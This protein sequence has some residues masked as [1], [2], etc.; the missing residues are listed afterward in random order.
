MLDKKII[1]SFEQLYVVNAKVIRLP[2]FDKEYL[3]KTETKFLVPE[4]E[5]NIK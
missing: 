3:L 4:K 2:C 1:P 5:D